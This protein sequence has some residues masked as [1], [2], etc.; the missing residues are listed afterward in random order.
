MK[1][2]QQKQYNAYVKQIT[3]TYNLWSRVGKAFVAGGGIC[4]LG[5]WI[6]NTLTDKLQLDKD[7]AAAWCSLLLIL[8]SVILT[9][10]HQYSKIAAWA[11][12]GALVPIT[13]FANSVASCAIEFKKEGMIFGTGCKIFTI[14][15]PVILYGII[16][17]WIL[18][19]IY[20][21]MTV[22]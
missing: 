17:S 2:E 1:Q 22:I 13:G 12:A 6:Q 21:L 9:A 8:L 10:C 15:G 20:W 11:G 3:P 16:T 14:A 4:V 5:Q 7:M 18:G 19:L